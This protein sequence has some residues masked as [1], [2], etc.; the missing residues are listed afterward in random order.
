[1]INLTDCIEDQR[2]LDSIHVCHT[3]RR[4]ANCAGAPDER[5]LME[6]MM[7]NINNR[8]GIMV[9]VFTSLGGPFSTGNYPEIGLK[10]IS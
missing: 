6:K 2:L 9:V 8:C 7:T 3:S 4:L 10:E 1:M 5:K